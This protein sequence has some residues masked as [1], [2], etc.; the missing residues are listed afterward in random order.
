MIPSSDQVVNAVRTLTE[1]LKHDPDLLWSYHCNIACAAVDSGAHPLQANEA[2]SRFL[3]IFCGVGGEDS[4]RYQQWLTQYRVANPNT[5]V[6]TYDQLHNVAQFLF[7]CLDDI[8]TASDLA[9]DNDALYR[10]LVHRSHSKRFKVADTDGYTVQF[11][12]EDSTPVATVGIPVAADSA[13]LYEDYVAERTSEAAP[14]LAVNLTAAPSDAPDT[15]TDAD[16]A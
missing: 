12:P 13:A 8:D 6:L 16:Q 2:A 5:R 3:K 4:E 11:K 14:P 10:N 1:A 15:N 9:K 7:K